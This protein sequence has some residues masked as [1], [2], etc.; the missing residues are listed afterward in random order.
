MV[1]NMTFFGSPHAG[2]R[3]LS[4]VEVM[5]AMSLLGV[6][7]ATTIGVLGDVSRLQESTLAREVTT[8]TTCNLTNLYATASVSEINAWNAS[9]ARRLA[10]TDDL[11][12][13]TVQD[14][15][16]RQ[17]IS[18]EIGHLQGPETVALDRLRFTVGFYR[19]IANTDASGIVNTSR[20]G[21]WSAQDAEST[22]T[23]INSLDTAEQRAQF[24]I[25][26]LDDDDQ[27]TEGN[28]VTILV[29][30]VDFEDSRVTRVRNQFT[31]TIATPLP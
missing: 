21:L 25:T 22:R 12:P 31:S 17:I 5:I 24:L 20:P 15:I 23:Q 28:P 11:S 4:L 18:A 9:S 26:D 29:Q 2:R 27:L 14:L 3:G 8:I 30:V 19:T 10:S 7:M 1:P 16:S 13:S 6:A